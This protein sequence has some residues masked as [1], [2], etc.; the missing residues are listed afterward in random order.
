MTINSYG[1]ILYRNFGLLGESAVGRAD[2]SKDDTEFLL[3][4]RK[5]SVSYVVFLRGLYNRDMIPILAERMT[6]EERHR[7]RNESFDTLW[8][9]LWQYHP[10]RKY[11]HRQ[12]FQK[13]KERAQEKF[14]KRAWEDIFDA[15]DSEYDEPEWGFPKGRKKN[16]EKP[17]QAALR[18]FSEE[19]GFNVEDVRVHR[20]IP[21]II[22]KYTATDSKQYQIMY[23]M[24][25]LVDKSIELPK[26]DDNYR[27]SEISNIGWF[28]KNDAL[29]KI[30][31]YHVEKKKLLQKIKIPKS[32]SI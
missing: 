27:L 2:A 19:T 10:S 4:C 28:N 12:K 16:M 18:E 5:D 31:K 17:I 20:D 29:K 32:V 26:I 8:D 7:L 13:Q 11:H 3:I 1:I 14:E 9:N 15:I 6:K 25:T 30:R 23:F 21:P 22:E 24:G